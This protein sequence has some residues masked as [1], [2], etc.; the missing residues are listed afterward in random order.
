MNGS[1]CFNYLNTY[2]WIIMYFVGLFF[3]CSLISLT[4]APKYFSHFLDEIVGEKKKRSYLMRLTAA[5]AEDELFSILLAREETC[6][7]CRG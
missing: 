5:H 2:V 3:F 6:P 7:R 4:Q 1:T